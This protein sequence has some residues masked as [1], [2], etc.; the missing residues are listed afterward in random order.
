VERHVRDGSEWQALGGLA[1][2]ILRSVMEKRER[3][4]ALKVAVARD[5][6]GALQPVAA[7]IWVQLDLPLAP[8]PSGPVYRDERADDAPPRSR[9]RSHAAR[10]A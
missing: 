9:G 3:I 10:T 2:G 4:G 5:H 8:A 7:A 1:S 6:A